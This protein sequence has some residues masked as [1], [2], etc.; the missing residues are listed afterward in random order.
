MHEPL[1]L[2]ERIADSAA[3]VVGSW[4][5]IIIQTILVAV[6]DRIQRLGARARAF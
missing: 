4:R 6:M 2:G 1:T 5:F 3:R